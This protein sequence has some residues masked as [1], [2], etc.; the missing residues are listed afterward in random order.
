MPKLPSLGNAMFFSDDLAQYVHLVNVEHNDMLDFAR[1]I[2][3]AAHEALFSA[4]VVRTDLQHVLLV[5][6]LQRAMTAF[7]STILLWERG[8]PQ[9]GQVV[10]LTL[11]EVTFKTVAIARHSEVATKYVQEDET[12]RKKFINIDPAL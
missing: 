9:D 1:R 5:S 11:L 2:N 7:Q 8:L 12:L 6:L 3:E 10:L 4:K